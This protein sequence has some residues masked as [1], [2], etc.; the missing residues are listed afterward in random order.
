MAWNERNGL[1]LNGLD[2]IALDGMNWF[3]WLGL[4]GMGW[5]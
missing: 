2:W 3:E 1:G 4:K 5:V